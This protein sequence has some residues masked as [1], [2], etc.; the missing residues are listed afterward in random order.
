M[1]QGTGVLRC[2]LPRG[3]WELSAIEL[4]EPTGLQITDGH[5]NAENTAAATQSTDRIG[6]GPVRA[7]SDTARPL[8]STGLAH[9]RGVGSAAT[10]GS[11]AHPTGPAGVKLIVFQESGLAA[12]IR[13]DQP[14]DHA[15]VPVLVD[16]QTAG[17]ADRRHEL[18]LN[19]DGV[20]VLAARVVGVADR[21]PSV[22]GDVAGFVVADES[23]LA[24]VLDA[25]NPGQG[26]A[27]ELW[28]ATRRPATLRRA[29]SAGDL[30]R[31]AAAF[32]SDARRG[33]A[34]D[35]AA[36]AVLTT[37]AAAAFIAAMLA[38][39]GLLILATGAIRDRRVETDLAAQGL[40]PRALRFELRFRLLIAT[41]V[42]VLG[43]GMLSLVLARL[44]VSTVRAA[45]TVM[46]P[47]P[48][49]VAVTPAVMLVWEL[50][51]IV[52]LTL[53]S[54]LVTVRMRAGGR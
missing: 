54:W 23:R 25:G 45:G 14:S 35:P 53:A 44:A 21:F 28:V 16:H 8:L 10:A 20:P 43:G 51:V 3:R 38:V 36:R 2:R 37:L 19:V 41:L 47:D 39:L 42:G 7:L 32:R 9:W 22:E 46:S 18:A 30:A 50:G 34:A 29:L 31:L 11:G 13:P 4:T 26:R 52:G 1:D 40:G 5:Q 48:P 12:I 27:D 24:A 17:A 49:V 33:I 6:I 15:P